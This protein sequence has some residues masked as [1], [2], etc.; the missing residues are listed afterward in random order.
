MEILSPSN[1]G[2]DL[3][4]KRRWYA[5][6][7]VREYWIV[8]PEAQLVEVLVLEDGAY[9]TLAR[10]AGDEPVASSVL[11]GLSFPAS[12]VFA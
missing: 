5:E 9:R 8:S 11:P 4:A 2:H 7:G 10:A 1:P 12:A 3:V 6:A